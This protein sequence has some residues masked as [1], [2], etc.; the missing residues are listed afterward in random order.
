MNRRRWSTVAA[1]VSA[2]TVIV[3]CNTIGDCPAASEIVPGGACSGNTLQCAYTLD[4]QTVACDGTL[5]TIATSCTCVGSV[6]VCPT[7]FC[8][9]GPSDAAAT[10]GAASD[11][12]ATDGSST[13]D[14]PS[15]VV[16][17]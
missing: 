8:D 15:D 9:G 2:L 14:G 4:T 13:G 11:G 6:W 16:Q 3:A 5:A 17:G 1:L 7:G 12:A 10:D